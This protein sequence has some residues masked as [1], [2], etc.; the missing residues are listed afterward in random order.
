VFGNTHR[1]FP[2]PGFGGYV[3]MLWSNTHAVGIELAVAQL[4]SQLIR[5]V[6]YGKLTV[7]QRK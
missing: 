4:V 2:Q 3:D 6:N 1:T 5:D 7:L